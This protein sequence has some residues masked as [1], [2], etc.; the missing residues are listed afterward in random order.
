MSESYFCALTWIQFVVISGCRGR[1]LLF[2]SP[3]TNH[4][5]VVS[6][7]NQQRSN[8][9]KLDDTGSKSVQF[10]FSEGQSDC[11]ATR[12]SCHHACT[13]YKLFSIVI[14]VASIAC[15]S[16]REAQAGGVF[17]SLAKR[18]TQ[19]HTHKHTHTHSH[20]AT[21]LHRNT[22]TQKHSHTETH[23]HKR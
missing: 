10:C 2:V 16:A 19:T 18:S 5:N 15:I 22:V 8:E 1:M 3:N 20:T 6:K 9:Q 11:N 12:D 13:D 17:P 21:Q 14:C 7:K 4:T 23:T